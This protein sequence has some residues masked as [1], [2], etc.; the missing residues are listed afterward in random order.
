MSILY[1]VVFFFLIPMICAI[2]GGIITHKILKERK[3]PVWT[4]KTVRLIGERGIFKEGMPISCSDSGLCNVSI[5]NVLFWNMGN[6]YINKTDVKK[7]IAVTFPEDNVI[8]RSPK[9]LQS[10]RP[11]ICFSAT[12][13]GNRIVLSFDF[14]DKGDGGLIEVIH[15]SPKEPRRLL[16]PTGRGFPDKDRNTSKFLEYDLFSQ[17]DAELKELIED[18]EESIKISGTVLGVRNV[19]QLVWVREKR[20]RI[21]IAFWSLMAFVAMLGC[22]VMFSYISMSLPPQEFFARIVSQPF[23]LLMVVCI[24]VGF[25]YYIGRTIASIVTFPPWFDYQYQ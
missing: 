17:R 3:K 25:A 18:T 20:A 19:I 9:I 21:R 16:S 24:A 4:H 12:R 10:S 15:S 14:L 2:T 8:L 23:A 13:R 7:D 22:S 11:E 6:K 5:T 1:Y